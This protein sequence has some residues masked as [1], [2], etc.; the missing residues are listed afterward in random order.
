MG[1]K[2]VPKNGSQSSVFEYGRQE[3]PR[4]AQEP[5][6]RDFWSILD[7]ICSI[8]GWFFDRFVDDFWSTFDRIVD[9]ILLHFHWFLLTKTWHLRHVRCV[10]ETMSI[11][12][13]K[14]F[15]HSV[16][17]PMISILWF[18]G[19]PWDPWLTC[20]T[21]KRDCWLIFHSMHSY[22]IFIWAPHSSVLHHI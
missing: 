7:G 14:I 8:C 19:D 3:P 2:R 6:K 15:Q 10:H 12:E 17:Q 13:P 16:F 1:P 9:R 22:I 5:S 21:F 18:P 20:G 4:P 11:H